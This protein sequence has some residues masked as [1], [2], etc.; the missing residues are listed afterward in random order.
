MYIQDEDSYPWYT[1]EGPVK[2]MPSLVEPSYVENET[3][4][5]EALIFFG[6]IGIAAVGAMAVMLICLWMR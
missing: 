6:S 3:G 4:P 1:P 2:I 5:H